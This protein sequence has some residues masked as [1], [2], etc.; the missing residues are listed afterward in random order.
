MLGTTHHTSPELAAFANSAMIRFLD[1]NDTY[2]SLDSGHP[3]DQIPGI[4]AAAEIA[5]ADGKDVI[6]ATVLGYEVFCG[7]CDVANVSWGEGKWY[8]ATLGAIASAAA[9]SKVLG[10]SREQTA[11]AISIAVVSHA[12]P[13]VITKGEHVPLWHP[14]A[15]PNAVRQGV[16][17]ALLAQQGMEGP[18][19]PFEGTN[20]F[21]DAISGPFPLPRL[22]ETQSGFRINR[23]MI[24]KYTTCSHTQTAA[25]AAL[26]VYLQLPP[27]AEVVEVSVKTN[28]HTM[29]VCARP[30][31]W[32]PKGHKAAHLSLPYCIA[33]ALKHGGVGPS[34]FTEAKI[35]DPGLHQF[36]QCIYVRKDKEFS[37]A[38]PECS[39]T[40]VEALDRS[41]RRYGGEAAYTSGFPQAPIDIEGIERKFTD[42]TGTVLTEH[43]LSSTLDWI[44]NL[45]QQNDMGKLFAH[46]VVTGQQ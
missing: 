19:Q 41:G 5:G 36:M 34:E 30:D 46:L 7:L 40:S 35:H 18:P 37:D 15:D 31:R 44:S 42:M 28:S 4:L 25:E 24:K 3:S 27:D 12:S 43:Q 20:G 29:E 10:L 14:C 17:A 45:D 39:T 32:H 6:T 26:Q 11:N 38:Y 21:F 13:G 2:H 22:G 1:Y 9:V 23:T 16:F 33:V 8:N